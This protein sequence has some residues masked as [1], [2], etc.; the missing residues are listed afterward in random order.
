M[1]AA[2]LFAAAKAAQP[3]H[4]AAHSHHLWPDVTGEAHAQAWRDAIRLADGKWGRIFDV[5]I[6]E[7]QAHIAG[8]LRLPDASTLAVAPNT[9]ELVTRLVSSLPRPV[10]ILTSDGEFHSFSRQLD[11]WAEAGEVAA[12]RIPVEP[13]AGFAD[14]FLTALTLG[15]FDI[16]YLSQVMFDSGFVVP[17]LEELVAAVPDPTEVIVDG[18]HGFMAIPTDLGALSD[19][20]FY[21]AGGYKYAM[22]GEA[23]CFM[24][25]PPGRIS[26][27]VDTGWYAGFAALEDA[28]HRVGYASGGGRF[29]GATFD[30]TPWYRFNAVQRMLNR[31]G[32]TVADIHAHVERLQARFLDAL[33]VPPVLGTLVP[34]RASRRGNFLTFRSEAASDVQEMLREA[35]VVVDRRGDRIR[36][37]FGVYHE[38][39]DVDRLV[40]IVASR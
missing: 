4:F 11:R 29:L 5:V 13:F 30:P 36:I 19:R 37:G 39:A 24:H 7:A 25:C 31:A 8:R 20:I 18:Y 10:R 33:P 26:R 2:P 1:N 21:V 35:G 28:T 16:V 14:R 23:A 32:I 34:D 12:T 9:H 17:G 22:A 27:P 6:A 38:E 15:E 3:L 40:E